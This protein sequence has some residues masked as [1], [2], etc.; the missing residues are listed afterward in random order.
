M[1]IPYKIEIHDNLLSSEEHNKI[2]EYVKTLQF[3]GTWEREEQ[4]NFNFTLDSPKNPSDWMIYQS[5]GRKTKLSRSPIATDEDSL[6]SSHLPIYLL[7]KKL[8]SQLGNQFELT[9]NPEGMRSEIDMPPVSDPN[10]KLGW[11]VYINANYNSHTGHGGEGYI[12][13]DTPLEYD[14][15]KTVTMLYVANTEWYPSWAG[16]LKFYPEDLDGVTGD[17]QQFNSAYQQQRGYNV[18]WLDQGQIVSP[19][20]GR[21]IVYDGRCLHATTPAAGDLNNP[22]IKIVFRARRVS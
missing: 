18:G 3:F 4:V 10:L 9:G 7:W 11:R 15:D 16:E 22:S 13:R 8:N 17:H 6:K 12:H 21:L 1:N 20:P 14:D 2:W 5:L 19:A